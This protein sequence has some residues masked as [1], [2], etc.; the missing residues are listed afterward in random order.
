MELP[1]RMRKNGYKPLTLHEVLW[2]AV[3][4]YP[5]NIAM[6]VKRGKGEEKK[7]KT[8]T[9]C[10]YY[11]DS[12]KFSKTLIALKI[13]QLKAVNIIGFNAPEWAISFYGS[14]MA[15]ILPV[16]IYT[17]NTP[18]ACY[19]ITDHSEAEVLIAEN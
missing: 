16:G 3:I 7:W 19:Y 12:R 15:N 17:T 8:W 9:Y 5:D 6:A 4:H 14:I 1:I 10:K 18:E 11:R 13:T 2:K